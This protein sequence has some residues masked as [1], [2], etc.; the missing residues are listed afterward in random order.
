MKNKEII[1]QYQW[2]KKLQYYT[3]RVK[4]T[5]KNDIQHKLAI[6]ALIGYLDSLEFF[7]KKD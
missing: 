6:C 2:V 5:S 4:D 3:Q 1:I 7:I